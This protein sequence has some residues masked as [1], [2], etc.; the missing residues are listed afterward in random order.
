MDS[1]KMDVVAPSQPMPMFLTGA[2]QWRL[3][4]GKT[5]REFRLRQIGP[6][7]TIGAARFLALLFHR[8]F[9]GVKT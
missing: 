6:D 5:C 9:D 7:G 3:C 1:R 2:E 8:F 4:F